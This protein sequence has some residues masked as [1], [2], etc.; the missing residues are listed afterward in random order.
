MSSLNMKLK[1]FRKEPPAGWDII[2]PTLEEFEVKMREAVAEPH[3]GKRKTE[4]NWG[5]IRVSLV[6]QEFR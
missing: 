1:K 5:V 2:E 4:A 6:L 3:E